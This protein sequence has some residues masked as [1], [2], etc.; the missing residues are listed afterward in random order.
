[1]IEKKLFMEKL[2][3][4]SLLTGFLVEK[5]VAS[6]LYEQV[7]TEEKKDIL[8][9]LKDIAYFGERINLANILKHLIQHRANRI[10]KE[11][12]TQKKEEENT[13]NELLRKNGMPQEV[14]QYIKKL[15]GY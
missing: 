7:K 9:A 10:E 11:A 1:M 2:K 15:R 14:R 6:A 5:E 4:A 12:Q 13:V 8:L 3:K